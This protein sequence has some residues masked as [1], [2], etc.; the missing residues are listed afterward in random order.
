[1]LKD[2]GYKTATMG[3]WGLGFPGSGS[4]PTDHGFDFNFG[5]NCQREAHHYY[6]KH[7]WRNKECVELDSNTLL[8]HFL[9]SCDV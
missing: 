3:K 2:A 6:P 7:L 4:E 9:H 5:C 1:L 8:P